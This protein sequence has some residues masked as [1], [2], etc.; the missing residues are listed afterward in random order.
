MTAGLVVLVL[1]LAIEF[2][3]YFIIVLRGYN[4]YLPLELQ[5]LNDTAYVP[6]ATSLFDPELGWEVQ[7]DNPTGYIGREK[8][9]AS[10][11]IAVF[12]DSYTQGY[13]AIEQ[14]WPYL[15]EQKLEKPVL[16]FGTG[17]YGTDQAYLRFRRKFTEPVATPYVA[18]CIMSENIA[19][20]VNVYRGFY[21]RGTQV[22]LT[23]P[24]FMLNDAGELD[25][26]PNPLRH[27]DDLW[28][29]ADA[30]FRNEIGQ[31]DYWFRY[32]GQYGLNTQAGFPY[33]YSLLRALPFYLDRIINYRFGNEADYKHL[34]ENRE[35]TQILRGIIDRFIRDAEARG[36]VPLILFFPNQFDLRDF[37]HTG[38]TVYGEF[39][40][41]IDNIHPHVFD[42]LDY[43]RPLMSAGQA[44]DAFFHPR[45][46][47][48]YNRSGE[49][50]VSDGFFADLCRADREAGLLI[51]CRQ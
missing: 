51:A 20:I 3:A 34:Y 16:N 15:L 29:I 39:L 36:A 44:A 22:S 21:L 6:P 45:T 37:E 23:K 24:R 14:S 42:G 46:D 8:P 49:A 28:Q 13:P 12:G 11:A 9:V 41:S 32:F 1:A 17:G 38:T 4:F 50:L 47:G 48:H 19:R 7:T 33:S 18:L 35:A 30:A 2:V 10:A 40:R 31:N 43:F 26:M 25:L 5:R 27:V